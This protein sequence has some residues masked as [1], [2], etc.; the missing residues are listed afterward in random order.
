VGGGLA[1]LCF[2]S[3]L[4]I[5]ARTVARSVNPVL[6]N[7]SHPDP[8]RKRTGLRTRL[9]RKIEYFPTPDQADLS[10]AFEYFTGDER[11]CAGL[12]RSGAA[13][14]SAVDV[15]NRPVEALPREPMK[16]VHA[17]H[18]SYHNRHVVASRKLLKRENGPPGAKSDSRPSARVPAEQEDIRRIPAHRTIQVPRVHDD[19]AQ[20]HRSRTLPR[21]GSCDSGKGEYDRATGHVAGNQPLDDSRDKSRLF[22]L[23]KQFKVSRRKQRQCRIEGKRILDMTRRAV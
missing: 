17:L 5:F 3:Q 4:A 11:V 18:D 6:K 13:A 21:K 22:H 9:S 1:L 16:V 12:I 10:A 2:L 19:D 8:K 14:D 15:G 20:A 23:H 7:N